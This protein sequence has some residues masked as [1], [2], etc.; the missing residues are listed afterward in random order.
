MQFFSARIPTPDGAY[1]HPARS[2]P[3]ANP[4]LGGRRRA[5]PEQPQGL[6]SALAALRGLRIGGADSS[7]TG[8]AREGHR[9]PP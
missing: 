5:F 9:N 6:W 8:P 2:F 4:V 7:A 1:G 3:T